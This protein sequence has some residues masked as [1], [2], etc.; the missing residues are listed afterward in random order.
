[1]ATIVRLTRHQNVPGIVY[2]RGFV[3]K[4]HA[5]SGCRSCAGI[6]AV[7]CPLS[8][9][10]VHALLV[11]FDLSDERSGAIPFSTMPNDAEIVIAIRAWSD[12][13]IGPRQDSLAGT[14]L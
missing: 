11:E 7:N 5:A 10:V 4:D 3:Q 1:M 13:H 14:V 6:D 12:A 8:T 2:P 9:P